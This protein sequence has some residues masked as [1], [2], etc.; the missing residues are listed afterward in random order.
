MHATEHQPMAAVG[1]LE[2]FGTPKTADTLQY[3]ASRKEAYVTIMYEDSLSPILGNI[4]SWVFDNSCTILTAPHQIF[5]G[6][7]TTP[8]DSS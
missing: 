1:C 2:I 6:S 7:Q 4:L 5:G 8:P 3:I